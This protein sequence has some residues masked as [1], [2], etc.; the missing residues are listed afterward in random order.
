MEVLLH[1]FYLEEEKNFGSIIF[2]NFGHQ[3]PGSGFT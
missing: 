1:F 3:N 2:F